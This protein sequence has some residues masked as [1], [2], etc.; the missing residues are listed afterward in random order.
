MPGKPS[1][2]DALSGVSKLGPSASEQADGETGRP[3]TLDSS[4]PLI[5]LLAAGESA[6]E[7]QIAAVEIQGDQS[8]VVAGQKSTG[9]VTASFFAKRYQ[10]TGQLD[11]S[12]GQA[13]IVIT[14]IANQNTSSS[15][16]ALALQRDGKI[17][18]VGASYDPGPQRTSG[19]L[20]RYNG[21][22]SLDTAFGNGGQLFIQVGSDTDQEFSVLQQPDG[23]LVVGGEAWDSDGTIKFA[24]LRFNPDGSPD[25]S[26]GQNGWV[27]L[28]IGPGSYSGIRKILLTSGGEIIAAGYAQSAAGQNAFNFALAQFNGDGS[29]DSKFGTNGTAV[30]P[31]EDKAYANDAQLAADGSIILTGP[32]I[33]R[34]V[35]RQ[36][37]AVVKLTPS[38]SLDQSFGSGGIQITELPGYS[39]NEAN[40]VRIAA[41]GKIVVAG[42]T[43]SDGN[44]GNVAVLRYTPSGE[45][46]T[47]FGAGGLTSTSFKTGFS[48]A[49]SVVIQ[50]SDG[51]IAVGGYS[52][53]QIEV[54]NEAL[55]RYLG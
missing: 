9:L 11:P 6:D 32:T 41:D 15:A 14:S 22:G 36:T 44:S 10:S 16:S 46:D 55:A 54:F 19:V 13:G 48:M 37:V 3:G 31:V 51:K 34:S 18:V 26:F 39:W 38:G 1:P 42:K 40:G 53:P 27:K 23:K 7:F 20:L 4:F 24:V 5:G 35:E 50:P 28:L 49:N 21:D 17:V 8:I 30:I 2:A 12:F 52:A 47:E 45:L 29:L 43:G 25:S 33:K